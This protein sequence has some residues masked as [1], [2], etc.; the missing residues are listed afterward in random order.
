MARPVNQAHDPAPEGAVHV[1][2]ETDADGESARTI[3]WLRE[4]LQRA[5]WWAVSVAGH[6]I[7]LL[8]AAMIGL[9]G[10]PETGE[11]PPISITVA[12]VKSTAP[13]VIDRPG[14]TVPRG[15]IPTQDLDDSLTDIPIFDPT[16]E[17]SSTTESPDN[18]DRRKR[19]GLSLDF[20]SWDGRVNGIRGTNSDQPGADDVIRPGG[21]RG[22]PGRHGSSESGRFNRRATSSSTRRPTEDAV[23]AGLQW[24]ARHQEPDGRWSCGRF[25]ANCAA[26]ACSGGGSHKQ[27]AGVTGLALLAFLGAAYVPTSRYSFE[28]PLRKGR[29]IRFADTVRN[30]LRWL[31]DQQDAEGSFARQ[32]GEFMYDHAIPALAMTEAAW[33]VTGTPLY[34]APAQR[35]IDFLVQ[36]QNPG[37]GWR[38]SVRPHVSDTS[39]TGWAVMAL[40]SA[41]LSG[42]KFDQRAVY[43]GVRRWLKHVTS[44]Q[45]VVGYESP[46]DA[47]STV[48]G[49][50]D[51]FQSHPV[52]TA[53]GLLSRIFIEK[54]QGDPWMKA[55][56][57]MIV[58]DLPAWDEK[59]RTIDSYYWY[60][61]AL[62]L[63]QYDAPD[64]A[65]W[66]AFN[67]SME[68]ALVPSQRTDS[69]GCR[70]GSWD[71]E[72][73]KWGHAGG[74]VYTTAINVLTLE[75]YY[76]YERVFGTAK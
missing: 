64:G 66:K 73:D 55:A 56:A 48:Q 18:D 34:K 28:D 71:P 44:V 7:L 24:L 62:A 49:V 38:Y 51:A 23:L 8:V 52:M 76:R 47:G 11:K 53:V 57:Q 13:L 63:F 36:A 21:D 6:L 19:R 42:L 15:G 68:K 58:R 43:D 35:G 26:A 5:P 39:V 14:S 20:V 30:G 29:R 33:L 67:A 65:A 9:A 75:I 59:H 4:T 2:G 32:E 69:A 61:A 72:V 70:R 22:G 10:R 3:V 74:R 17:P 27:D 1:R 50:N 41:E 46:G 37:A 45:G 31:R 54:R 40:K 25:D 16:A 12:A 60:Y